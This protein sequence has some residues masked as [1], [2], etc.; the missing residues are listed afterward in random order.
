MNP[1]QSAGSPRYMDAKLRWTCDG[2]VTNTSVSIKMQRR[3]ASG[4]WVDVPNSL[5][6][7][8]RSK[9]LPAGERVTLMTGGNLVCTPGTYRTGGKGGATNAKGKSASIG[10]AYGDPV[11]VSCSK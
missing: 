11:K 9:V 7:Y 3:T 8:K 6:T 5:N 10:W 4:G 2:P 1:H